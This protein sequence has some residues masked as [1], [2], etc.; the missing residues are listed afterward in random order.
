MVKV[1]LD[2]YW[3]KCSACGSDGFWIIDPDCKDFIICECGLEQYI[4]DE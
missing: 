4:G 1:Y 3:G 2:G